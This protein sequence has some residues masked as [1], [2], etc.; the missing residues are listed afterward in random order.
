MCVDYIS[1]LYNGGMISFRLGFIR[2][3]YLYAFIRLKEE[4]Q[5]VT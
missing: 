2:L 5:K 1:H 4:E 3:K